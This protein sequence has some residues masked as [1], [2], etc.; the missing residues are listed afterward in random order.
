MLRKYLGQLLAIDAHRTPFTYLESEKQVHYPLTINS[1]GAPLTILL[2][3]TVDRIDAKD[4]ITRII[5]Y[6]TGGSQKTIN[7]ISELFES[8]GTRDPYV[9]QAFYYAH[10]LQDEYTRIAPS[11]LFVRQTA[12]NDFEPD[13]T[14]DQVKVT[15]YSR[16]SKEF[17]ELL[18]RTIDE[19]FNSDI[20]YSP[21]TNK[22]ACKYC[23]FTSLCRKKATK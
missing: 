2:G 21:T 16:Y 17:A 7:S 6:K 3:G 23:K 19:I 13:I 11:L 10:L 4:G 20:P 14:I 8:N 12:N 9:F 1:H 18:T 5:D 22:D 15:D